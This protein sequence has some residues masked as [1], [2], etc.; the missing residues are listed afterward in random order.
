VSNKHDAKPAK[1]DQ[2]ASKSDFQAEEDFQEL[3]KA[4]KRGFLGRLTNRLDESIQTNRGPE[5]A[6]NVVTETQH[7]PEATADD[8]AIRRART[9]SPHRMVIP[10]G[11]I[12]EGSLTGGS[13]TEIA[14]RIDGDITIDGIL[15]L[16]SSALVSGNVRATSCR[17]DGLVEGRVE[18]SDELALGPN[19]RLNA[20]I[21]AGKRINIA[22]Q[23]YGNVVTPGVLRLANNCKVQGDV[24]ARSLAMEEG[25]TLN[26][27]CAMRAP[28][29]Q[30]EQKQK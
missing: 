6:R 19:G 7:R 20:D 25:A 3:E 24:R 9:V 16:G 21:T 13:E 29:Q 28:S 27:R 2:G 1:N 23:V 10:E 17:I 4:T 30:K 11:V 5:R 8:V 26:G 15:T 22:G 14:G 12:I 18:V